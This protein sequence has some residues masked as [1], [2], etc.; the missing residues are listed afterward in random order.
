ML[1][2]KDNSQQ[3]PYVARA[4]DSDFGPLFSP[5][6]SRLNVLCHTCQRS[7]GQDTPIPKLKPPPQQKPT[8]RSSRSSGR[9]KKEIPPVAAPERDSSAKAVTAVT[10]TSARSDAAPL[11]SSRERQKADSA[12]APSAST[13][14]LMSVRSSNYSLET[15]R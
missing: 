2:T 3:Q 11:R 8:P 10:Q 1:Y 4:C 13:S 14:G 9:E 7:T 5:H 15:P 12:R 6:S